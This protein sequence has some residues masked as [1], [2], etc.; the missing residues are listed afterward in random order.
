MQAHASA[1]KAAVDALSAST[2]IELGPLGVTSNI[3][4][5]GPIAETEG[6]ARLVAGQDAKQ[7]GKAVPS[8]RFG[9]VREI[10]DAT[11]FLFSDA[12]SYINGHDLVGELYH[13]HEYARAD[14]F[15]VDGGAWRTAGRGDNGPFQYPDFLLSNKVVDGVAGTKK[16]K[17]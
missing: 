1:A 2:A 6:V 9:T 4:A 10:A 8:G 14:R 16:A 5:P 13:A 17:L 7:T 3:I 11:I 15:V 12:G